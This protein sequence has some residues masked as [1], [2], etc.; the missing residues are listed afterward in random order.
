M[1]CRCSLWTTKNIT[2]MFM[3][4]QSTGH[5][6]ISP[7]SFLPLAAVF[8]GRFDSDI[9]PIE[10]NSIR[11]ME[12][13]SQPEARVFPLNPAKRPPDLIPPVFSSAAVL[14]SP[15]AFQT[16]AGGGASVFLQPTKN[17]SSTSR[18]FLGRILP[19]AKRLSRQTP[20]WNFD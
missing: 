8:Y 11:R 6:C 20:D 12:I 7:L 16:S 9:F 5:I 10:W 18:Y 13:L 3:Y 2:K 14:S 4:E 19:L 1:I 17:I 15:E